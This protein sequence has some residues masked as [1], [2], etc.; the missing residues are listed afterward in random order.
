[1]IGRR[2]GTHS[3][4]HWRGTY[5]RENHRL[6]VGPFERDA[7]PEAAAVSAAAFGFDMTDPEAARSWQERVAYPLATDPAGAFVAERDGR[8]IGVVEAIVRERLWCLSLLAVQ[9]GIQS[10]GAGRALMERSLEYGGDADGGLIVASN[11]P[12]AM[13]LYAQSGFSLLPTLKAEGA[14][15][16]RRLPRPDPRIREGD[17]QDLEALAEISREVRGAAHTSELEFALGRDGQLLRLGDRGF[18][19][20]R[21]G[22]SLWLLV[23]RDEDAARALLWHGLE[24]V[25]NTDR[26]SVRWITAEQQWAIEV[27]VRARLGLSAY[28]ALCVRG[29]VGPLRPF[30]PSGPFA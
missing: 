16:R 24:R 19:V 25:G 5:G 7:L 18:A 1:V 17:H 2:G 14:T 20:A 9:P 8:V 3:G 12:R 6:E 10:A 27:L 4:T 30:I 23:A 26:A 28:G 29:D 22:H 15:D 21:P 11:D 13:R